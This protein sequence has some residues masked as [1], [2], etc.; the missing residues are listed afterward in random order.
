[1]PPFCPSLLPQNNFER[2]MTDIF[3]V[4]AKDVGELTR[5]VVGTGGRG[6]DAGSG[7]CVLGAGVRGGQG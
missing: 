5:I 7:H 2:N 4:K 6:V 1:M 3:M